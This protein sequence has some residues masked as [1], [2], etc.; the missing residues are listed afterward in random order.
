MSD[1]AYE[2]R[3]TARSRTHADP[4]AGGRF[5]VVIAALLSIGLAGTVIVATVVVPRVRISR[6]IVQADFDVDRT[7]ILRMAGLESPPTFFA[8]QPVEIMA[9]LEEHPMVRTARV[10]RVFPDTVRLELTRR[11]PLAVSLVEVR[12]RPIPAAIDDTGL[13]YD[14]GAHVAALNVPVLSGLRYEGNVVGQQ[15]PDQLLPLLASLHEL[16]MTAPEIFRLISEIRV[17][18]RASGAYDTLLFTSGF[19]VPVRMSGA[20]DHERST[21][22]LMVLDVLSQQGIAEEVA[23]L[24]FRS[25][26]IVFRMKEGD[27]GE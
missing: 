12:G 9:R 1:R 22:A 13:I 21:Y 26:E 16:K 2:R 25:R 11:R 18:P 7:A 23:E 10:E 19:P 17:E 5:L 8:V 20:L 14:S 15:L 27:R 3:S 6:V 4:A 24:D